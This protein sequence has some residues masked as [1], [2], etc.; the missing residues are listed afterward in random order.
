MSLYVLFILVGIILILSELFIPAFGFFALI[1]LGLVIAGTSLAYDPTL[2]EYGMAMILAISFAL[3][4]IIGG[5]GWYA[6]KAY[7]Q[8]TDTGKEGLIG[9]KAKIIDWSGTQGRVFIDGEN[10]H[11]RSDKSYDFEEGD[12]VIV[13]AKDDLTLIVKPKA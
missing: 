8:K 2:A 7:R 10:W 9:D 6:W 5:G 13:K 11:A 1:G 12:T 3:S 4:L